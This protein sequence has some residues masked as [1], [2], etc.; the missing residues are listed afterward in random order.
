MGIA[1]DVAAFC[2]VSLIPFKQTSLVRAKLASHSGAIPLKPLATPFLQSRS[3][4]PG[5]PPLKAQ[6]L[7]TTE[8]KLDQAER[9]FAE[10]RLDAALAECLR[11]IALDPN[12]AHAYYVLGVIQVAFNAHEEA[13][14]A[15][16]QSVK[17]DPF[18]AA[19]HLYLA[20][21]YLR[22]KNWQAAENGFR[23]ALRLG[24]ATG[25]ASYGLAL[26]LIAE[27]RYR[28]AL[29]HLLAAFRANPK[30]PEILFT[31]VAVQL[32]LKNSIDAA[33]HMTR[34][35]VLSHRNPWVFFRLG[36]LLQLNG[37]T[38]QADAKFER[39]TVL[40]AETKERPPTDVN[41]SELYL[42]MARITFNRQDYFA[43]L[44]Y[45]GRLNHRT[46]DAALQSVALSLEGSVFLAVGRAA[47]SQAK[48]RQAAEE[49]TDNPD[50]LVLLIWANILAGDIK[51]A[52]ANADVARAK[53][54]NDPNLQ[55]ILAIVEREQAPERLRIPPSADWHLKGE[56]LVCC[57]CKV[58]CPCRSNGLPTYRHCENTGVMRITEGHYAN[59]RLDGLVFSIMGDIM[60]PQVM[61][62]NLYVS[63]SATDDE[64]IALE[65]I[66]Q[67]FNPLHPWMFLNATRTE[68]SFVSS[69][70]TKAYEVNIPQLLQIKIQR[71]FDT[72]GKPLMATAALD[73]F[74]N[75]L[76]YARNEVYKAW[77]PD[78]S[79]RWDYSGRQANYR[80]IDVGF[81]DYQER[82]MLIQFADGSGYFNT[83]QLELVKSLRLPTLTNYPQPR[84]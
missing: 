66:F 79:V 56:G 71:Q 15:L 68:L 29:P 12:S 40:L 20:K 64:L 77:N 70:K 25:A 39:A 3:G 26:A 37:M 47:E 60:N 18:Q 28:D 46:L 67:S 49:N 43:T 81:R 35:E 24:E 5:A 57:P 61:P 65:R 44:K 21:L 38:K 1:V 6:G 50:S 8:R 54:P 27:P 13:K 22:E 82:R 2:E 53:W 62:T 84:K 41:L 72:K 76:E 16:L 45:L 55:G 69:P 83:N 11:A 51:A 7:P 17:L 30:D 80:T 4:A 48:L 42:Q 34:L 36:K 63:R 33:S 58:P 32:H 9:D 52:I 59:V 14:Q 73:Y 31:L 19:S 23:A 74:S 10:G 75:T 78:G